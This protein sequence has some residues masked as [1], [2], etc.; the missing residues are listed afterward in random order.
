[1]GCAHSCELTVWQLPSA[2]VAAT[3]THRP[4][5]QQ[6]EVA[7]HPCRL[8]LMHCSK[9]KQERGGLCERHRALQ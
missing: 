8:R 4:P 1:M 6:L 7:A 3:L 2:E 5:V 9:H